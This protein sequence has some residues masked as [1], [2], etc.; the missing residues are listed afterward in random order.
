MRRL[1]IGATTFHHGSSPSFQFTCGPPQDCRR[2]QH[3]HNI[4][5]YYFVIPSSFQWHGSSLHPRHRMKRSLAN[6]KPQPAS[7][8]SWAGKPIL[9]F[10]YL[11]VLHWLFPTSFLFPQW[12]EK[13]FYVWHRI[14]SQALSTTTTRIFGASVARPGQWSSFSCTRHQVLVGGIIGLLWSVNP[15]QMSCFFFFY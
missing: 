10:F 4:A 12:P 14:K 6:S 8:T 13:H 3:A 5:F 15:S 7:F 2:L 9:F 1:R 11:S